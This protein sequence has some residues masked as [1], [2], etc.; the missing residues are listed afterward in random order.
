ME[1]VVYLDTDPSF[2]IERVKSMIKD[3]KGIPTDV[4]RFKFAEQ[5][6][7]DGQKLSDY[8]ILDGAA[9]DS[10]LTGLSKWDLCVLHVCD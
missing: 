9:I 4:M 8:N 3:K 7:E 2:T 10:G 6:L 5:Q 1:T